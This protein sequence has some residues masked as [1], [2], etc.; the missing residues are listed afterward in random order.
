MMWLDEA[1]NFKVIKTKGLDSRVIGNSML[2]QGK[3][4]KG[5]CLSR[6]Y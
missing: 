1:G 5:T 4:R 6:K 2:S 3:R